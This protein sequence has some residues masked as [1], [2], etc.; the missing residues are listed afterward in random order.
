MSRLSEMLNDFSRD[1]LIGLAVLLA[2]LLFVAALIAAAV[3]G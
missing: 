2:A 3:W 1:D